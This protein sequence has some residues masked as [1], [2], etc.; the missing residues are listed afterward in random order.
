MKE[1]EIYFDSH[2]ELKSLIN[3]FLMSTLL[4]KPEDIKVFAK[5]FFSDYL[6]PQPPV[7]ICSHFPYESELVLSLLLNDFSEVFTCCIEHTSRVPNPN[8]VDGKDFY[9]LEESKMREEV[10]NGN[11]ITYREVNGT[12]YGIR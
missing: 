10:E 11:F 9:F 6:K 8:E 12:L 4:R 7:V 1:N 2:P 5:T 3:D